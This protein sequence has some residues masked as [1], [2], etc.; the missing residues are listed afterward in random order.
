[1]EQGI[2]TELGERN[3]GMIKRNRTAKEELFFHADSLMGVTFGELKVGDKVSFSIT[4]SKKG[5][6]AER[7]SRL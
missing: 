2:I 4:Q 3:S 7:V 5:P 6:Y 1:M